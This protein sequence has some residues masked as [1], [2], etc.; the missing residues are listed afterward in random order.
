MCFTV[1]LCNEIV[2]RSVHKCEQV[3]KSKYQKTNK[4]KCQQVSKRVNNT[5]LDPCNRVFPKHAAQCKE[6]G[7][8]L[9]GLGHT[10][11]TRPYRVWNSQG[12][13]ACGVGAHA[14]DTCVP[15]QS[16]RGTRVCSPS[17]FSRCPQPAPVNRKRSCPTV[18]TRVAKQ[19][20]R[21]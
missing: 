17:L 18:A 21:S 13:L 16:T 12:M 14:W 19:R 11:G 5:I 4:C 10:H 2:R 8:T 9:T 20:P 1:G 3:S 6:G 7:G 15:A